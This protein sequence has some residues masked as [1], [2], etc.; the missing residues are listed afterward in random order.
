MR[1]IV[2]LL[3]FTFA[4]ASPLSARFGGEIIDT[5]QVQPSV[6]ILP[7]HAVAVNRLH[8]NFPEPHEGQ[9]KRGYAEL[10][11]A[12]EVAVWSNEP[13]QLLIQ[14]T[15]DNM[16]ITPGMRKPINHLL[17][18]SDEATAYTRL[19][20]HP[21]QVACSQSPSKGEIY[22]I[23]LRCEL[24]WELDRPNEYELPLLFTLTSKP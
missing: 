14:A 18:A 2:T 1:H 3:W 8:S 16:S 19:S 13:W 4:A 23:D 17:F 12:F 22:S 7:S 9:F 24:F 21:Q 5:L 15:Q 10:R 6:R 20:M 11:R